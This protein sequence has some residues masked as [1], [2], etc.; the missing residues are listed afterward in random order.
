MLDANTLIASVVA[1]LAPVVAT[2]G[3][4]TLKTKVGKTINSFSQKQAMKT[5]ELTELAELIKKTPP[6]DIQK[7]VDIDTL[8]RWFEI[9]RDDFERFPRD[10]LNT[11][12]LV[13]HV[14]LEQLFASWLKEFGYVVK[15]GPK[16]LGVEE[17]EFIPDVYAEM[18]T[19]HGIFQ[20]AINFICDDPPSTNRTSFLCES[21]EAFATKREPEFSEKDIFMLVTPFK[22]SPTT[23]S[24][25]LKEDNDHTYFVIKLEGSELR[26]L[27]LT[28]SKDDRLT[29]LQNIVKE[30]HGPGGK[31]TWV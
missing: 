3:I 31:K 19:L 13:R 24:V 1:S 20:I 29:Q 9:P 8:S 28:S 12:V 16:M 11:E 17:W 4:D 15:T 27:Q 25:I 6:S 5:D 7:Q 10:R 2:K 18:Y 23:H 26:Q 14:Y 22:F 30:A 21:L